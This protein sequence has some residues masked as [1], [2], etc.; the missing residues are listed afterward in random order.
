MIKRNLLY[1]VGFLTFAIK[2]EFLENITSHWECNVSL[3]K[4]QIALDNFLSTSQNQMIG[5]NENSP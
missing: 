5:S 2:I 4:D 3:G 1:K